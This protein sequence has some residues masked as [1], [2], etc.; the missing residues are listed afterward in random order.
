MTQQALVT[1]IKQIG[2][3]ISPAHRDFLALAKMSDQGEPQYTISDLTAEAADF[4]PANRLND[5]EGNPRGIGTSFP[6]MENY[7]LEN[8]EGQ[9][10]DDRDDELPV[11]HTN[12][13]K[14]LDPDEMMLVMAKFY[15]ELSA[16]FS[17]CRGA[18]VQ[19]STPI[20]F[21]EQRRVRLL[22]WAQLME[23]YLA[24]L[25]KKAHEQ[26]AFLE[27]PAANMPTMENY[28]MNTR[29]NQQVQTS[30]GGQ[31]RWNARPLPRLNI[32]TGMGRQAS[33]GAL[34][35]NVPTGPRSARTFYRPSPTV[36]RGQLTARPAL[37]HHH[38]QPQQQQ[39]HPQLPPYFARLS[40]ERQQGTR[41]GLP[42]EPTGSEQPPTQAPGHTSQQSSFDSQPRDT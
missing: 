3:H 28:L 25:A 33:A 2:T 13:P 4:I 27:G 1:N 36:Q 5:S 24:E 14:D 32:G 37:S 41:Q 40:L 6:A 7:T 10:F 38:H 22:K 29:G 19:R 18:P 35:P 15:R 26:L 20:W 23:G 21:L 34:P 9:P 31:D 16:V 42:G 17:E 30:R 8:N 11:P 12:D 39:Q